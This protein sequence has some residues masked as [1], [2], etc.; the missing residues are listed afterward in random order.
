M[1]RSTRLFVELC[2]NVRQLRVCKCK[3]RLIHLNSVRWISNHP[4][5]METFSKYLMY[6]PVL[7]GCVCFFQSYKKITSTDNQYW[8]LFCGPWKK[9]YF[10]SSILLARRFHFP[11][12]A[13]D[14]SIHFATSTVTFL[15]FLCENVPLLFTVFVLFLSLQENLRV[16]ILQN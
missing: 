2:A 6:Y 8:V 16:M 15:N 10:T 5:S 4:L 1:T 14:W 12:V 7:N 11:T 13:F 3:F 9:L